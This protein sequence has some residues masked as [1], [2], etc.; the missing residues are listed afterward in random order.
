MVAIVVAVAAGVAICILVKRAKKTQMIARM[1]LYTEDLPIQIVDQFETHTLSALR[2]IEVLVGDVQQLCL[3]NHPGPS[4]P[5]DTPS[6][7]PRPPPQ[8][9]TLPHF[10]RE[11][12]QIIEEGV[13]MAALGNDDEEDEGG[14]DGIFNI[15]V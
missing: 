15:E 5:I 8:S 3:S 9:P 13:E 11:R 2:R 14:D 1:K 4:S 12:L 10:P 7:I 6:L